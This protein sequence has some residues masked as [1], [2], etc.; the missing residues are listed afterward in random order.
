MA[1][2]KTRVRSPTLFHPKKVES[3]HTQE[4]R[5][6]FRIARAGLLHR[7]LRRGVLDFVKNPLR[8]LRD[9]EDL[10]RRDDFQKAG[11]ETYKRVDGRPA[12]YG[13]VASQPTMRSVRTP[14]RLVFHEPRKTSV[15]VRRQA[16]RRVLFALRKAGKGA[17]RPQKARWT[18]KSY[19]QCRRMK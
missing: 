15:C 16:R 3:F 1:R 19:V 4:M 10:R 12:G 8:S 6:P 11:Q 18:A 9:A 2:K 13:Y 7:I 14:V 5:D 17:K